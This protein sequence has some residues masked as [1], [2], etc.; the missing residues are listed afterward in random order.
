LGDGFAGVKWMGALDD[1]LCRH[2][3]ASQMR[4]TLADAR[5]ASA[6][7]GIVFSRGEKDR[8]SDTPPVLV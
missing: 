1:T 2:S 4:S 3:V 8:N 6:Q 7:L 5:I